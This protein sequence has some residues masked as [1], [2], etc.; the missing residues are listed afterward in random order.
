MRAAKEDSTASAARR[1]TSRNRRSGQMMALLA[2]LIPVLMG[3][4]AL[5]VDISIFYFNWGRL[6]N[7]ADAAALAGAGYLPANPTQ[8]VATAKQFAGL[9]G[10]ANGEITS[11]VAAPNK[12][13]ITV[14]LT[15]TVPYYFAK[16]LGLTSSPVAATATASVQN[17]GGATGITPIGIQFNTPYTKGQSLTVYEGVAPGNWSALAL[18][19]SG[20]KTFSDN[21]ASGYQSN[22]NVNDWLNVQTKTG[23]MDGP[24][25]TGINARISDGLSSD[26]GG[27]S[28]SH[29]LDD[30]RVMLVPMV[31]FAGWWC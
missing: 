16:V 21:L 27:T 28:S 18:G 9:N 29:S 20:A 10:I 8:A 11:V 26:P 17:V 2:L 30:A 23:V 12:M 5:G 14:N 6:Q 22:V 4:V 15:R 13:S 25:K 24:V 3:A 1:R 31:D 7:A 19:G